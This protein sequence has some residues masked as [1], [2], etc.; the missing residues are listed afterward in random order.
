M[1]VSF[2]PFELL[3]SLAHSLSIR[4][5]YCLVHDANAWIDGH[6]DGGIDGKTNR[7]RKRKRSHPK[8]SDREKERDVY[9]C[10]MMRGRV[11]CDFAK[12][13]FV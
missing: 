1:F 7:E 5:L 12:N 6:G 13:K 8:R 3:L 10:M 4:V 2:E 9:V 11:K